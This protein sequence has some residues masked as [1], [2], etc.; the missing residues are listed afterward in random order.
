MTLIIQNTILVLAVIL[1]SQAIKNS[2][3]NSMLLLAEFLI[4]LLRV[5]H[6]NILLVHQ[7]QEIMKND[8][9]HFA[10]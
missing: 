2:A 7:V 1:N 9:Y 3:S 6:S 10:V 4:V 5:I 8:E